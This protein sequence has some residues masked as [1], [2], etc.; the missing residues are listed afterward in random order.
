M[1]LPIPIAANG[2][3]GYNIKE[4]SSFYYRDLKNEPVSDCSAG[5]F[6]PIHLG[7]CA[8]A[9]RSGA[10]HCSS[11]GCVHPACTCAAQGRARI[12][13]TITAGDDR[14][15]GSKTTTLSPSATSK[16]ARGQKLHALHAAHF[17]KNCRRT[18]N[19]FHHG[20]DAFAEITTWHRWREVLRCGIC[21]SCRAGQILRAAGDAL[22]PAYAERYRDKGHGVWQMK[23]GARLI[24]LPVRR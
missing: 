18:A 6:N 19:C 20:H 11:R 15:G 16:Q 8:W 23:E 2:M 3:K 17:L 24:F 7:H 10:K 14:T 9:E 22:P 4:K 5:S 1:E 21:G 13:A 12:I